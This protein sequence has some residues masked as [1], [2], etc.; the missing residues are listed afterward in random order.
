MPAID[1]CEPQ[2]VRALEKDGWSVTHQPFAIRIDKTRGGYVFADLRLQNQQSGQS[3]IV[4][5]VKC[6]GSTRT[7]LDEFYQAIGQYTVYRNALALNNIQSTVYLAIPDAVY[8]TLF[9]QTLIATVLRDI[10]VNIVVV[11]L[12]KEEITQ[13]IL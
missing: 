12:K 9:Q 3:A 11:D 7:F 4:V 8:R 1:R 10:H 6:F 2:I 13:W 5:E